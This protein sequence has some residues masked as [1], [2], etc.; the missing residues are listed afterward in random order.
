[1]ASRTTL[2]RKDLERKESAIPVQK[3]PDVLA[4][5]ARMAG[6]D[7]CSIADLSSAEVRALTMV[8]HKG[9]GV[10]A[11]LPEQFRVGRYHSLY[12]IPEKLPRCFE[13]TAESEDGVIM[14]IR[15]RDLP[16]DAHRLRGRR[17]KPDLLI[18][19][20]RCF[21][22]KP[23]PVT[24]PCRPPVSRRRVLAAGK[25]SRQIAVVLDRRWII[26]LQQVHV[27]AGVER[28]CQPWARPQID[29][30]SPSQDV[31]VQ[32]CRRDPGPVPSADRADAPRSRRLYR[33]VLA[34]RPRSAV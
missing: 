12:A 7:L 10:F 25:M 15:H 6:E 9:V 17:I 26:L 2:E 11:D 34:P 13:V 3:D 32:L 20:L 14:G 28:L 16:M 1:M 30:P 33:P 22:E 23:L 5:A 8:R 27:P 29:S 21:R 4:A 19:Q 24:K 31:A 18:E